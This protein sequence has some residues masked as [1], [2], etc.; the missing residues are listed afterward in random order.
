MLV[1]YF[2]KKWDFNTKCLLDPEN[3]T[4]Y[5]VFMECD[6]IPLLIMHFVSFLSSID[7]VGALLTLTN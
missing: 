7:L 3:G 6:L 5:R 2:N 4:F 1:K